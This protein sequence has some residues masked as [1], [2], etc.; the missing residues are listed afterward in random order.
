VD[1]KILEKYRVEA[2]DLREIAEILRERSG[3]ALLPVMSIEMFVYRCDCDGAVLRLALS[4]ED[5]EFINR[6][7]LKG[8]GR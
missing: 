5:V 6:Q 8:E 7:I 4:C 3:D 2:V 1:Q